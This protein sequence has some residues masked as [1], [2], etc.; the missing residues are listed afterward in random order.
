VGKTTTEIPRGG[1]SAAR[2]HR[3][4]LTTADPQGN[5]GHAFAARTAH[6]IEYLAD[7]ESR[8]SKTSDRARTWSERPGYDRFNAVG[9]LTERPWLVRRSGSTIWPDGAGFE[10]L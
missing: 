4:L 2:G 9:S 3:V 8:L 6:T 10:R 5:I 7:R 1:W